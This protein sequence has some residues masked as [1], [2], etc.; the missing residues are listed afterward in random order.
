LKKFGYND[1]DKI[2]EPVETGPL[3]KIELRKTSRS[4]KITLQLVF[5]CCKVTIIKRALNFFFFDVSYYVGAHHVTHLNRY[6]VT[7]L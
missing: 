1:Q 2:K 6:V 5:F 4:V 7:G 3:S